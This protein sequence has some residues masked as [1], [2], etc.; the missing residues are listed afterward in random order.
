MYVAIVFTKL[1]IPGLDEEI[2]DVAINQYIAAHPNTSVLDANNAVCEDFLR[3]Y[4]ETSFLNI[5][6]TRFKEVQFFSTTAL[7]HNPSGQKFTPKNVAEPLLWVI[8]KA[9][10]AINL[11]AI[12][13]R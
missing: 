5:I 7:G 12:W 6:K 11:N 10:P 3:R 4:N 8:D 9:S 2:G 1:D 13:K